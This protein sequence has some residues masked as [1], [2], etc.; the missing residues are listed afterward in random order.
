MYTNTNTLASLQKARMKNSAAT[1]SFALA[2]A[3]TICTCSQLNSEHIV[4]AHMQP[5]RN[6]QA[7][8]DVC[9]QTVHTHTHGEKDGE[10][11]QPTDLF[12]ALNSMLI[13][14]LP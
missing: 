11:E 6:T 7:H 5:V 1:N 13:C 8:D 2:L 3:H 9:E 10:R 12:A 14:Y 4:H